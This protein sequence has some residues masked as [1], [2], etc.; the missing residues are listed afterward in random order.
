MREILLGSGAPEVPARIEE[1][2][3]ELNLTGKRLTMA[4]YPGCIHWHYHRPGVR[5]TLEITCWPKGDRTWI[6]VHENRMG[7]WI[8]EAIA[9]FQK[10]VV[11]E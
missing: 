9:G 1:A 11:T 3:R 8:E 5:G 4:K 10:K 7:D 2:A 6:S